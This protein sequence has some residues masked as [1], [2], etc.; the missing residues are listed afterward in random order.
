[1]FLYIESYI[2]L[3]VQLLKQVV[4]NIATEKTSAIVATF[5]PKCNKFL[6]SFALGNTRIRGKYNMQKNRPHI[7]AKNKKDII[8]QATKEKRDFGRI[9]YDTVIYNCTGM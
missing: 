8:S 9:Y 4:R 5:A 3:G 1:M 7:A 6:R 2:D